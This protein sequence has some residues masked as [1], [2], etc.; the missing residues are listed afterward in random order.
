MSQ[1]IRSFDNTLVAAADLSAKQFYIVKIDS[2]AKVVLA[3][4]ALST[5]VGVLQNNP[6]SGEAA[7]YRFLGTT[8][9]VAGGTIAVGALVTSD[10]NG[11]A[12]AT[13]TDGHIV[14]GR[15]IGTSAAA[16]GDI[17]EVQMGIQHLY[18]A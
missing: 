17:V 5:I 7:T 15:H 9:V 11:K 8:K 16:S 6:V 3:D 10:A 4:S 2:T 14:I 13:T 1:S 12:V 18:I